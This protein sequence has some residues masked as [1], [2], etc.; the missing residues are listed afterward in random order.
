MVRL[1]TVC[2]QRTNDYVHRVF[3][4]VVCHIRLP[5]LTSSNNIVAIIRPAS[6][7]NPANQTLEYKGIEYRPF[8]TTGS[9]ESII[10]ALQ[11][12]NL[13]ISAIAPD[14]LLEQINITTVAKMAGARRLFPFASGK[15]HICGH[16]HA[17]GFED[18]NFES[19]KQIRLSNTIVDVGWWYQGS[20]PALP[21]G[22]FD[23]AAI[24]PG[25][26]IPEHGNA[27]CGLVN[28]VVDLFE[29]VSGESWR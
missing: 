1:L 3:P 20:F 18:R 2:L 8:H 19:L 15:P 23:C 12:Q 7:S 25:Q 13:L 10:L 27:K 22:K 14:E 28:L 11:D 9:Q 26:R 5:L 16:E 17:K 6:V 24:V 29:R 4:L 21:S